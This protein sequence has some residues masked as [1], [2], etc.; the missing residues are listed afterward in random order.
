MGHDLGVS[1]SYWKPTE[2][3]VLQDY[4]KA[5]DLLTIN[6]NLAKLSREVKELKGKSKDSEVYIIK[7]RLEE[8]DKQIEFLMKK[9]E[10]TEQSIY[11]IFIDSGQLKPV[12]SKN[13]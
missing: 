3:D 7:G 13:N 1:E 5:V 12:L 9:Q 4:L 8:K 10:N 11:F 2:L 6:G